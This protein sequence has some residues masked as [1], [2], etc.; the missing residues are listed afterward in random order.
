MTPLSTR[1][2]ARTLAAAAVIGVGVLLSTPAAAAPPSPSITAPSAADVAA[3]H[4]AASS[5]AVLGTLGGFFAHPGQVTTRSDTAAIA[6]DEALTAPKVVGATVPVYYLNPA[7]VTAGAPSVPVAKLAFLATAAVSAQGQHAS[8]W[9]ARDPRHGN[10]WAEVNIASGSDETD[11]AALA[12][13]HGAGT[14]AFYEPQIHAW[15]ALHGAQVL[16]LNSDAVR[17]VGASGV[18]LAAYQS[19]VHGR[20]ADKMPGSAYDREHMVGGFNRGPVS[21][22]DA[23]AP[24]AGG[25]N[26]DL[27]AGTAI[28]AVALLGVAGAAIRKRQTARRGA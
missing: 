26:A 9:T 22:M 7:F 23:T 5:P 18:S 1:M 27:L 4:Q 19:L 8:V 2:F 24:A 3:A 25:V 20:Y 13:K 10:A 14:V 12:A 28:G 17:S 15:Y 21:N 6:A 11:Y 16:P